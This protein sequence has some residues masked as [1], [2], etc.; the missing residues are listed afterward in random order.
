MQS[1]A[2]KTMLNT[3]NSEPNYRSFLDCYLDSVEMDRKQRVGGLGVS[4]DWGE[5][6][7][8]DNNHNVA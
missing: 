7:R 3:G 1:L 2:D 6:L 8:G 5:N 4:G